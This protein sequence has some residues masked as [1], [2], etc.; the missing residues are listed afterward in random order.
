MGAKGS[1]TGSTLNDLYNLLNDFQ[2][3]EVHNR[4]WGGKGYA[5]VKT[6]SIEKAWDLF[7]YLKILGWNLGKLGCPTQECRGAVVRCPPLQAVEG[8]PWNSQRLQVKIEKHDQKPMESHEEQALPVQP[9]A[10]GGKETDQQETDAADQDGNAN[11]DDQDDKD[12]KDADTDERAL[13][14]KDKEDVEAEQKGDEQ[15]GHKR[16]LGA[17]TDL[18]NLVFSFA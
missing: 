18:P 9:A 8:Y 1:P 11:K 15:R 14:D 4:E 12:D 16:N 13:E 5:I 10:D 17:A 6:N 7:N 3:V 2:P